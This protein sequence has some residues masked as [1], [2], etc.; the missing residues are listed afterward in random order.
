V[1][2]RY[3][4]TSRR[5]R[6]RRARPASVRADRF[7]GPDRDRWRSLPPTTWDRNDR[8]AHMVGNQRGLTVSVGIHSLDG[9]GGLGATEPAERCGDAISRAMRSATTPIASLSRAT[10]GRGPA[11]RRGGGIAASRYYPSD[12]RRP[13]RTTP[14]VS[15]PTPLPAHRPKTRDRAP[16]RKL[17]RDRQRCIL[18]PQDSTGA[19]QLATHFAQPQ[20]TREGEVRRPF[21]PSPTQ[22]PAG[23][24]LDS[25]RVA[26]T[27]A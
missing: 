13:P 18:D 26:V 19:C 12:P 20:R 8:M 2:C 21:P 24:P 9:T 3:P 4:P 5:L 22:V 16:A 11:R 23:T 15:G 10:R 6:R 25:P 27:G 1:R 7:A 14:I 17:H